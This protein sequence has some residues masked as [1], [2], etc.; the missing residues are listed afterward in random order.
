MYDAVWKELKS[1]DPVNLKVR[2]ARLWLW[3][4]E[5]R[6]SLCIVRM[7]ARISSKTIFE[8][9]THFLGLY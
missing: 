7:E 1:T 2:F 8:S 6:F 9:D 3:Y 4:V 5:V